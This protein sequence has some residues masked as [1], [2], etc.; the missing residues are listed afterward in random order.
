MFLLGFVD[1]FKF[2]SLSFLSDGKFFSHH[3]F[4]CFP[5][6]TPTPLQRHHLHT[7]F[8]GCSYTYLRFLAVV[9]QVTNTLSSHLFSVFF[10]HASFWIISVVIYTVA[11]YRKRWKLLNIFYRSTITLTQN[12]ERTEQKGKLSVIFK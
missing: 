9:S 2:V 10:S 11:E 6:S 12:W 4:S 5:W 3:F 7:P 1:F 8:L